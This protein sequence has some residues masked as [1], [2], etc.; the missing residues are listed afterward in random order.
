M[1]NFSKLPLSLIAVARWLLWVLIPDSPGGKPRKVPIDPSRLAPGNRPENCSA[2]EFVADTFNNTDPRL[3]AQPP[4]ELPPFAGV[5]FRFDYDYAAPFVFVDLDGCVDSATG[6]IAEWAK[7]VITRLDS[8][9]E[10]SVSG[11]GIH[12]LVLSSQP[13]Q[14]G[15]RKGPIEIYSKG[16]WAAMTGNHVAGTPDDLVDRTEELL[17][18]HREVFGVPTEPQTP[19]QGEPRN[20]VVLSDDELFYGAT[21][22]RNGARF[23]QLYYE[24]PTRPNHSEED[25]ELCRMLAFWT[26]CNAARIDRL[27][28]RSALMR[29]KWLRADYRERTIARAIATCG[30]T[31]GAYRK[32]PPNP[33]VKGGR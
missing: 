6:E 25:F 9:T 21:T 5:G 31:Y 30:D 15:C 7:A 33:P 16:R 14:G 26:D 27:F 12:I 10:V 8:Y 32:A 3:L 29:D 28:R 18:F 2:F 20:A 1:M 17:A 19:P 11:T 23:R 4:F 22:A 24:P 13:P